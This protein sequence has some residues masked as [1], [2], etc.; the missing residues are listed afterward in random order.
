VHDRGY[1][2]DVLSLLLLAMLGSEPSYVVHLP[3]GYDSSRS[4][5]VLYVADAR[6]RAE[7]ALDAFREAADEFGFIV[8]SSKETASDTEAGGSI[9]A[10]LTMWNE[11]EQR[12]AIDRRRV[13]FTGFSG[14]ARLVSYMASAA[15]DRIRGVISAGAGV[16]GNGMP[17]EALPYLWF[18]TAGTRDFNYRE[19]ERMSAALERFETPHRVAYFEG[20]HQWPPPSVAREALGWLA[21]RA[22]KDGVRAKDAALVERLWK[23]D[24]ARAEGLPPVESRRLY[25]A[26]AADYSGLRDVTLAETRFAAIDAS[27]EYR[28][29]RESLD[30]LIREEDHYRTDAERVLGSRDLELVPAIRAL[31]IASLKKRAAKQG[32]DADAAARMLAS[33]HV[34]VAFYLPRIF[35][36]RG[37]HERALL[38]RQ[39]AK[40]IER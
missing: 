16:P 10:I 13:Y 8:V 3:D 1:I 12:Y 33:L 36:E 11:T 21:L 26:M 32:P 5:P 38:C 31:K 20:R 17:T 14:T 24:L 2:D 22:M 30:R 40:E 35:E 18:G 28:Q 39:L 27:K 9:E 4:W 25:R 15:P 19:L 6:G 29:A 37:E 23:E 34:Q 7:L